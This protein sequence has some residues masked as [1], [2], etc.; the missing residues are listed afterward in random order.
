MTRRRH[1]VVL[2]CAISGAL[3]ALIMAPLLRSGHL[4]YRDAVSTPRSFITDT[5]LGVGDLP[6]RAVPQDWVV[7]M[8]SSVVDGGAVV[9][10][11]TFAALVCAGVG[12]GRL[13]LRLVGAA[14][15]TG[16]AAAAMV[17]IWNPYVAERL[18][19]GHW[20]LLVSYAA[21]GWIATAACDILR[22]TVDGQSEAT[23]RWVPWTHLVAALCAAAFTPTGSMLSGVLLLALTGIGARRIRYE[24]FGA[25]R[26]GRM[27]ALWWI[28]WVVAALPWLTATLVGH[29]SIAAGDNGF[30]V[31]GV[32]AEPGLG[33]IG[34]VLG[35]GGIWNAEAVPASRTIWWA[36]VATAALLLV[37]ATG[38]VWLWRHRGPDTGVIA[39]L[40][41]VAAATAIAVSVAAI[42][43]VA[44]TLSAATVDVP[45]LGLFRDTQKYLA[46]LVPFVAVATAAAVAAARRWVPAG[47]A[48]AATTLL[49]VA[50]LPDLAWGV[51]GTIS[52]VTYPSD[53][54][55][56][57]AQIT[58][59]HGAVAVWPTGSVRQY[60]FT[61][62]PSL[63]PLPRMVRA[64][65]AESGRLVVDS[66]V[67]DPPSGRG[68]DV[69]AALSAG[70][71]VGR[72]T[73]LGV[74]WVV[75][76]NNDPPSALAA[77]AAVVFRGADLTLY[78]IPGPIADLGASTAARTTA[79]VA[80]LVWAV[81]AVIALVAA[82]IAAARRTR[83]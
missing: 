21:L 51:G 70:G 52:P 75:V 72:L 6:P 41:V 13:A 10:A 23:P 60:S 63:D 76:E 39:T 50:P 49:I 14:G 58:A 66:A 80:H 47:F 31:F 26:R 54:A 15:R 65:V 57:S 78:R 53:W 55:A 2:L 5:T 44:E 30:T 83:R 79:I 64:P 81:T 25:A 36:A 33:T 74:G 1:P 42:G 82:L 11:I 22:D 24:G 62:G 43:P 3:A 61:D 27:L 67:V 59:D 40:G 19:Q 69:D 68:A 8:A 7:A 17:A 35:L 32:R 56:V 4:L 18:L 71:S 45:G 77:E 37:I 34:T 38:T 28:G 20:S 16:A 12:Y 73:E 29:A 48:L 46:L 9:V